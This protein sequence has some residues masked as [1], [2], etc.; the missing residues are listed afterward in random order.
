MTK[1]LVAA[2][3]AVVGLSM[4]AGCAKPY[5]YPENVRS[6]V[7]YSC[8]ATSHNQYSYCQCALDYLEGH[9]PLNDMYQAEATAAATQTWPPVAYEAAAACQ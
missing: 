7:Y 2:L 3:L 9:V 8:L 5:P 1:P 4:L 6:N